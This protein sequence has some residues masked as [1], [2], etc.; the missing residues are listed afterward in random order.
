[1]ARINVRPNWA[2]KCHPDLRKGQ[3]WENREGVRGDLGVVRLFRGLGGGVVPAVLEPVALAVHFQDVDV[4]GEAVQQGSGEAFRA[5]DLGP[6]VEGQI[7][8]H[9]DGA[10]FRSAG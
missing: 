3:R 5:E 6:L 1:M 7:G 9:Q 4:V 2:G 8:G 10:P